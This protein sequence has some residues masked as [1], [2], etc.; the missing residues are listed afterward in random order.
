MPSIQVGRDDSFTLPKERSDK[1][2]VD[3]AHGLIVL[4][5]L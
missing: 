5:V 3:V 1:Q 4:K 2:L